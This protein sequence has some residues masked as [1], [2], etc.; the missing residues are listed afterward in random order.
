MG[1]EGEKTT[2]YTEY[3]ERE[4]GEVGMEAKTGRP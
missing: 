4:T 1:T 3:A 2:E